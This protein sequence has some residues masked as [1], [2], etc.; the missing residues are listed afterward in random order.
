MD[1]LRRLW[2]KEGR[3]SLERLRGL[4][5]KHGYLSGELIEASATM[6]TRPAYVNHFGG[7]KGAYRAIGY[8]P[9]FFRKL[10]PRPRGLRKQNIGNPAPAFKSAMG[11]SR[12]K[13]STRRKASHLITNIRKDSDPGALLSELEM[14]VEHGLVGWWSISHD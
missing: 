14:I 12:K 5:D 2:Q 1:A 10:S 9:D 6:P 13:S 7:L 3:L 8:K 4:L 11:A